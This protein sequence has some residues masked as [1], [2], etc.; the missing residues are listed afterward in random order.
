MPEIAPNSTNILDTRCE[1]IVCTVNT[2]GVN[3]EPL[4]KAFAED[5]R[6]AKAIQQ[7]QEHANGGF[8][9]PG[10]AFVVEVST[11][12]NPRFFIALATKDHWADEMEMEWVEKG[13]DNLISVCREHA[14]TSVAIPSIDSSQVNLGWNQV[15]NVIREKFSQTSIAF[16]AFAPIESV[17]T[18]I[19]KEFLPATL[20]KI[21]NKTSGIVGDVGEILEDVKM[22]ERYR[23]GSNDI[24][25]AARAL[26]RIGPEDPSM[27]P[28]GNNGIGW[29]VQ[30]PQRDR[31]TIAIHT[32]NLWGPYETLALDDT[33]YPNRGQRIQQDPYR[34][35]IE[36]ANG[37]REVLLQPPI[38]GINAKPQILDWKSP[39]A[40]RFLD[41]EAD[42]I[43]Y[44][45]MR[46]YTVLSNRMQPSVDQN[47]IYT[48][49]LLWLN[50][51]NLLQRVG[52][53]IVT[54]EI[55]KLIPQLGMI[56]EISQTASVR[57]S[58]RDAPQLLSTK[59]F[60][61][62]IPEIPTQNHV[63]VIENPFGEQ[64][65]QVGVGPLRAF[66]A[67]G[68]ANPKMEIGYR[69]IKKDLA[70][71]TAFQF[72]ADKI[73]DQ[74]PVILVGGDIAMAN[75]VATTVDERFEVIERIAS[76]RQIFE[77]RRAKPDETSIYLTR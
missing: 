54:H 52:N 37:S 34:A 67:E 66:R 6:F 21:V 7:Y 43:A 13:I 23:E 57:Y 18:L 19:P 12:Q 53:T 74:A 15:A 61:L 40:Q 16:Q 58:N 65:F 51:K 76:K 59:L 39:E 73:R 50:E 49:T 17:K 25:V 8:L 14:I 47:K 44:E 48:G 62:G 70:V 46:Q 4:E 56:P 24:V 42:Q 45:F 29:T 75:A 20:R 55:T 35:T 68:F 64:G 32:T 36:L 2:V 72:L 22:S 10:G 5:K 26:Y 38:L 69:L 41:R 63:T 1:A 30:S 27:Q 77:K 28:R 11:T 9:A 31:T 60:D 3:I 71:T 33:R